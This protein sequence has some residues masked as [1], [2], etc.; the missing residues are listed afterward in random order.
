MPA[1]AIAS[2]YAT[3][4]RNLKHGVSTTDASKGVLNGERRVT[5]YLKHRHC[6]RQPDTQ[7]SVFSLANFRIGIP[8]SPNITHVSKNTSR[9]YAMHGMAVLSTCV[10][11][12]RE[13]ALQCFHYIF[14]PKVCKIKRPIIV[15]GNSGQM[16][17][18]VA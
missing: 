11:L 5:R 10:I 17:L 8:R 7:P 2:A 4:T 16:S 9:Q 18:P 15:S 6:H 3:L 12:R 1:H 14:S 13:F